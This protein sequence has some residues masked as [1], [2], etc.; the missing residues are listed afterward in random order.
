MHE[1]SLNDFK[2]GLGNVVYNSMKNFEFMVA[3][4]GT[5]HD[6]IGLHDVTPDASNVGF[7]V[8][9]VSLH[10]TLVA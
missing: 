7:A 10:Q 2:D 3:D 5:G 1:F 8:D 9:Y 6:V 4:N